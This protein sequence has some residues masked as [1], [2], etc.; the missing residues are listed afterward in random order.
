MPT[1]VEE[2]IA[3]ALTRH[4][5]RLSRSER[6]SEAVVGT[7]FVVAAAAMMLLLPWGPVSWPTVALVWLMLAVASRVRFPVPSGYTV[8][9][10][11]VL[12][13]ALFTVPAPLLPLV[14]TASLAGALIPDVVRRR[15]PPGR[16]LLAPGNS[17]FG[18]GPALVVGLVDRPEAVW[19][20][21]VLVAGAVAAQLFTDNAASWARNLMMRGPGLREQLDEMAWV[22]AVDVAFA[23]V[24]FLVALTAEDRPWVV[25]LLLPLL[26]LLQM[27]ATER[28][29]RMEQLVELSNAYRGTAMVLGD[30]VESDDAYTGEHTRG[31]VELALSVGH[32]MG[33]SPDALQR[34]EFGAL[35]HDV[36]KVAVPKEIINKPGPLDPHEWEIIKTHTVEGQRML[37][38]VGGLMREIGTIVRA[39]HE[40]WDGGGYPDGLAGEDIPVESRIVSACDTWNAMTTTRSYRKALPFDIAMQ[41]L[42]SVSGAQLD[43]AVVEALVRVL[44]REG[45]PVV[46]VRTEA[47]VAAPVPTSVAEPAMA[48]APAAPTRP[49]I[50]APPVPA[51]GL[52]RV[53]AATAVPAG[54][55]TVPPTDPALGTPA[56]RR[57]PA[58]APPG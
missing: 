21:G 42:R 46:A 58:P 49:A 34:L 31:V 11:L 18:I 35:L 45:A 28:R 8:P 51:A 24:G 33:L 30:V 56:D 1:R 6:R 20:Q 15:T 40:R 10:E 9:A 44:E 25:G 2:R 57:P 22:Y 47:T 23:P 19:Q 48:V 32:Q 38:T 4:T 55:L 52:R 37:D 50:P 17:W 53:G 41:E 36:G 27:F 12:V 16:L 5:V 26:G 14:V 39:H 13:P 7:G 43:P 3:D 54:G 29:D